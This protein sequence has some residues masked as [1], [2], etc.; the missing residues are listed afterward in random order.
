MKNRWLIVASAVGIH[1]SIGSLYAWSV[2]AKPLMKQFNLNLMEVSTAFSIA[3]F[4][5]GMSAAF[6]GHFVEARGPA[7]D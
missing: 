6:F 4:F 1:I 5:L 7:C 3:I 2:I